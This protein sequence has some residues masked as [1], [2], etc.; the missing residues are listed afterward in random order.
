MYGAFPMW[1]GSYFI[2]GS[3]VVLFGAEATFLPP[4]LY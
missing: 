1:E 4:A 2:M 3:L